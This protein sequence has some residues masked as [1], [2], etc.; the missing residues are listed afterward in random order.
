MSQA[1]AVTHDHS[2]KTFEE[3]KRIQTRKMN[4]KVQEGETEEILQRFCRSD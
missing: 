1:G 3:E 2:S 4:K